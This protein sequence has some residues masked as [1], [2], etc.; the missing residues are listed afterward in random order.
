MNEFDPKE[1][2]IKKDE[3]EVCP[4][5]YIP[6]ELSTEGKVGAPKKFYIRN[7]DTTDLIDLALAED[8]ELPGKV[9]KMLN[10]LIYGD[11]DIKTFHEQE[12]IE[13]LVTLYQSFY[14][15]VLVDLDFEVTAEDLKKLQE[16]MGGETTPEYQEALQSLKS[17][18]WK[19]KMDI[20]LDT[21]EY[22]DISDTFQKEVYIKD[23]KTGFEAGFGF[24][25][26]GDVV[27]LRNLL[28]SQFADE[29]KKYENAKN[30]I[31]FRF[32]AERRIREGENINLSRMPNISA[33]DRE[34]FKEYESKKGIYG[35]MAVKAL[36]LVYLDGEDLH[37]VSLVDRVKLA[38]NPRLDFKM[39]SKVNKYYESL[40]IGIKEEVPMINPLTRQQ[41]N[42][43][44]QFRLMD[45]FQAIKLYDAD[46]YDINFEPSHK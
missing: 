9:I 21:L 2:D 22:H 25:K 45:I 15:S 32:D 18:E 31:K 35:V 7:F 28:R 13:L 11:I 16:S 33:K 4:S 40:N 39:M 41:E 17:G 20:N 46:E 29:D 3:I 27:I 42:R 36:H 5:G 6:V 43:R 12:V 1:D 34:D 23:K 19:P 8:E 30:I 14:N 24:P 44:F 38:S 10:H 26:Y 37:D